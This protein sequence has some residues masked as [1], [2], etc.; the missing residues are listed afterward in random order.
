[1]FPRDH[2][3]G[4]KLK[5]GLHSYLGSIPRNLSGDGMGTVPLA[6]VKICCIPMQKY[7]L[8]PTKCGTASRIW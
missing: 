2:T 3:A 7:A 1:M 4:L 6:L 8:N 5:E